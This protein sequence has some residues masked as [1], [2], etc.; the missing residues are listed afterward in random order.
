M[1]LSFYREFAGNFFVFF[2]RLSTFFFIMYSLIIGD[3]PTTTAFFY[4]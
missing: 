1:A 2:V 4:F 3:V